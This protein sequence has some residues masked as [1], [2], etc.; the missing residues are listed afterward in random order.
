M[1]PLRLEKERSAASEIKKLRPPRGDA[2]AV[3]LHTKFTV[4]ALTGARTENSRK[5]VS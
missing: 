1:K 4:R 3:F 5:Q 2:A